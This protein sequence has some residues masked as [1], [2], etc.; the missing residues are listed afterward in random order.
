MK[1]R[2]IFRLGCAGIFAGV[3]NR[4]LCGAILAAILA[5]GINGSGAAES[6]VSV[7]PADSLAD[8]V[9]LIQQTVPERPALTKAVSTLVRNSQPLV[10]GASEP[11]LI[12]L[13]YRMKD[14]QISNLAVQ[15][16][17]EPTISDNPILNPDGTVRNRVGQDLH[18][19]AEHFLGLMFSQVDYL[20]DAK[21]IQASR[22]AFESGI[23]GD[24]TFLRELT[25][26]PLY[27]VAVMPRASK[28]L[29]G[30]L[31]SRV[32]SVVVKSTLSFGDWKNE[33]SFVTAD[34]ETAEQV[35][36]VVAAWRDMAASLADTFASHT[37]GKPLREALQK[38]SVRV[39]NN[40]VITE[41]DIPSTTVVRV[42]KEL[43]G[44]AGP[45]KVVICHKGRSIEVSESAVEAHLAHGDVLGPCPVTICHKGRTVEVP[46]SAVAA[47][48]AHGDT[49]GPCPAR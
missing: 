23:E 14:G 44:H 28:Y 7:L 42:S 9:E 15:L 16:F 10:G 17:H 26:E 27:V 11:V 19:A 1:D 2:L 33:I 5:L 45:K 46:E 40:Q 22:R 31:R 12:L 47:H 49:I 35:G 3:L 48:L 39:A 29:P 30:S 8:F 13:A 20:G 34:D 38:S 25:V 41:A 6:T 36:T 21:M 32:Q 4:C 18:Q 43:A 24:L 37:S